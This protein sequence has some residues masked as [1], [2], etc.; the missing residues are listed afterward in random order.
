[1]GQGLERLE[2]LLIGGSG[3][4]GHHTV[5]ALLEAGHAVTVVTRG[6]RSLPPGA[7]GLVA[8]RRDRAALARV[9]EGRR[10]DL[11]VDFLAYDAAD[12]EALLF[13]PYATLG[14]YVMIS[15]GQVYL[16]T[17]GAKAPYREDDAD[18]PLIA[19]P[20]AGSADHGQWSY[21]VGKRRAERTLLGYRATHGVR[22][23]ILRLPI[24]QGEWD[25][26][27]RLWAY[28]ERMLD[29]GPL[30]LPEGGANPTRFVWAGDV[31]RVIARL[32]SDPGR[33]AVYNVAQPDVVPLRAYLEQVAH[34]A[35][36]SPRFVHAS[37]DECWA[38]GLD[39][40]FSPFSGKWRSLLDPSRLATE[41]GFTATRTEDYL[42]AVVR[43]H[44]EHRPASHD[45]YA[46]RNRER[47]LAERLEATSGRGG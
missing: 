21:G 14:R 9:L 5:S 41:W 23:T 42:P 37:W 6:A 43:W 1:M 13:V 11:T 36:V 39:P 30:I 19:E 44:L 26:S 28:L 10:F 46:S 18:G 40:R 29:G 12:V 34:A 15:T 24:I 38:A 35:G 8:D 33:A 7:E 27:R 17:E 2:I 4:L 45:G 32:A 3:F 22:A 31:G 16:V 47:G 25:G 20:E